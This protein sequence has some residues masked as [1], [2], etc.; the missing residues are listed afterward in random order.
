MKQKYA[1]CNE[2]YDNDKKQEASGDKLIDC[3]SFS[4]EYEFKTATVRQVGQRKIRTVLRFDVL[5]LTE[6]EGCGW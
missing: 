3:L 2:L 5:R 1:I 4:F 6:A